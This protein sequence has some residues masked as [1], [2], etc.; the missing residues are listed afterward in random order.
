MLLYGVLFSL[1]RVNNFGFQSFT[2]VASGLSEL[3]EVLIKQQR[4]EKDDLTPQSMSVTQNYHEAPIP[5][6]S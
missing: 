3:K 5:E 4:S 6:N 1:Y 2:R